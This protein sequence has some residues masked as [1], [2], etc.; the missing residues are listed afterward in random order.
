MLVTVFHRFYIARARGETNDV[1]NPL[2]HAGSSSRSS[3]RNQLATVSSLHQGG[4]EQ[5]AAVTT[6]NIEI[7]DNDNQQATPSTFEKVLAVYK[8]LWIP[9]VSVILTFTATIAIFPS[10]FVI[11]ESVDHCQAGASRFSDDLFV[12]VLFSLFNLFDFIGRYCGGFFTCGFTSKTIWMASA[13][14]FL[15][16]PLILLCKI[17]D[18]RLP[19]VFTSDA[20]PL[21]FISLMAI[22]NGY[23]ATRC[24]IMGASAVAPTDSGLAG[25]IMIFSLTLGLLLG[26]CSSFMLVFI[27]QGSV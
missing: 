19:V 18:S 10:L 25:T 14:R 13:V 20:W 1:H 26:A 16:F 9:S 8:Q 11:V 3:S 21:L 7:N 24:M 27:S 2:I 4:V 22:S 15:F 6:A 17:Q 5:G 23:V 12:P